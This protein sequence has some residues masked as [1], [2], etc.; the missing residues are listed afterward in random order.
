MPN[1]VA[2]LAD[3]SIV[4]TIRKEHAMGNYVEESIQLLNDKYA[5]LL[6]LGADAGFSEEIDDSISILGNHIREIK[7]AQG[8][9]IT[10]RYVGDTN[11]SRMW[12][13]LLDTKI[14]RAMEWLSQCG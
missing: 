8:N 13:E 4:N 12:D 3:Y 6:K 1:I 9:V 7:N 14:Q 2:F 11:I 10:L 5:E